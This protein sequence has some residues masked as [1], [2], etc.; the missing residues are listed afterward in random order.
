MQLICSDVMSDIL[1]SKGGDSQSK[2]SENPEKKWQVMSIMEFEYFPIP[3]FKYFFKA[4]GIKHL[5][6]ELF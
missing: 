1:L 3:T 5:D 2:G 6:G 4:S